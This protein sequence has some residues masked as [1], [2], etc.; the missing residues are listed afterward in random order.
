MRR[1]WFFDF[2]LLD[3]NHFISHC[4]KTHLQLDVV[5]RCSID[6]QDSSLKKL[7]KLS[8]F[9]YLP[10]TN[11]QIETA[12]TA[13]LCGYLIMK[14]TEAIHECD[15]CLSHLQDSNSKKKSPLLE[16]IYY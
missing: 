8:T 15:Y 12:A 6:L 16:L 3:V 2:D 13:F 11:F 4:R 10:S 1:W 14:I 5:K 9:T 7:E